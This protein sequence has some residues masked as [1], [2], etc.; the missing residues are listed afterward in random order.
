MPSEDRRI[1]FDFDEVYK[2][3]YGL[4]VRRDLKK[5]PSGK[6]ISVRRKADDE[7]VFV[8]NFHDKQKIEAP[9]A[10]VEYS[11]DF[12]AASLLLFCRG[13][14][15]PIPKTSQKS[16]LIGSEHIILRIEI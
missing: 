6:I 13:F 5:P 14:E 15:I 3:I 11:K 12:I 4:C 9:D 16:V 1:I 8:L 2:A 10:R 7:T